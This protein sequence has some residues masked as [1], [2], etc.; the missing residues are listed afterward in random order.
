MIRILNGNSPTRA[1]E[2]LREA[3]RSAGDVF[4][5]GVNVVDLNAGYLAWATAQER[6]LAG[7][8]GQAEM[9]SFLT[10]PRYW[11]LLADQL[12]DLP[13]VSG[14][15]YLELNQR[16]EAM[17]RAWEEIEE[18]IQLWKVPTSE[19]TFGT[20]LHAIVLDTNVLLV[21]STA[22]GAVEW[23]D[24]AGI[25]NVQALSLV[26]PSIVIDEL[27]DLKTANH[28]MRI[29][30]EKREARSLARVALRFLSDSFVHR[31]R[32]VNL[33]ES[34]DIPRQGAARFMTLQVDPLAHVSL[35]KADSEIVEQ[36]IA[37]QGY[38]T[39]VT[40]ASYDTNIV[41]SARNYGLKTILLRFED[42]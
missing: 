22:L 42:L 30:G 27:D 31:Q 3:N 11:A 28:S 34:G 16:M 12:G 18:T 5:R 38:A 25:N 32:R 2:V 19:A 8:F 40:L 14:Q 6:M 23:H 17:K 15:I 13:H 36:A 20:D 35:P 9:N 37:L 4:G 10:S 29:N 24:R 41:F 7:V 1:V 39:S 26:V 33:P 21:H